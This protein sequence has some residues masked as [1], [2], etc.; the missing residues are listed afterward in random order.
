MS[1]RDMTMKDERL[2]ALLEHAKSRTEEMFTNLVANIHA[3]RVHMADV[4]PEAKKELEEMEARLKSML[5]KDHPILAIFREG[6][7]QYRDIVPRPT[8]H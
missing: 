3:E 6:R 7:A 8:L 2:N 1:K 4:F 5:P